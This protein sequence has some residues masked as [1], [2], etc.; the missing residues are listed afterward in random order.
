MTGNST[1][2]LVSTLSNV[3]VRF[4]VTR[5]SSQ[6]Q[7]QPDLTKT[8]DT[9]SVQNYVLCPDYKLSASILAHKA[10]VRAVLHPSENLIFSASR[11]NTVRAWKRTL[12]KGS[13]SNPA[14]GW[15]LHR[16]YAGHTHFVNALA[17]LSPSQEFPRGLLFSSGSDK[18]IHAYDPD[19]PSAQRE[20]QSETPGGP[21]PVVQP[22]YTL[23]GHGDN[24]CAL[25]VSKG[26][27]V[28]S[29]SWDKTAKLWHSFQ[30]KTT[31]TGHTQAVWSVLILQA[32]TSPQAIPQPADPANPQLAQS[33]QVLTASADKTIKRWNV[34]GKCLNT[35]E[36][37]TDAVRALAEVPGV[38]FASAG[39]DMTV[40]I[41]T[42]DGDSLRVLE[43]HSS[44]VYSLVVSSHSGE[45]VSSGE[46]RAVKVWKDSSSLQTLTHSCTSVWSVALSP[47]AD[48][49]TGGSDGFV[50]VFTRQI[51]RVA[52]ADVL[53]SWSEEVAATTIPTSQVGSVD[54]SK[55]DPVESLDKRKGKKEGEVVMVRGKNGTPEAYEWS[56]SSGGWSKIGD[57]VDAK[58]ETKKVYQGKEYDFVFDVELGPGVPPM[59][60][61]YNLSDNPWNAA[62]DF[63][64]KNDLSQEF[65]DQIA[66]F[67]VQQT[68]G[69]AGSALPA[70]GGGVDPFTG[71]GR[72]VPGGQSG[73]AG[74]M[75]SAPRPSP[76][77]VSAP[78]QNAP[79]PF[80]TGAYMSSGGDSARATASATEPLIPKQGYT[81]FKSANV[82]AIVAKIVKDNSDLQK[83]FDTTTA[84]LSAGE[85]SR[86]EAIGHLLEK[87]PSPKSFGPAFTDTDLGIIKRIA[88][89]WPIAKRLPGLDLLRLVVLYS[90][91]PLRN[92]A[93]CG[94]LEELLVAAEFP[95]SNNASSSTKEAENNQMLVL[96][97]I[98][99]VMGAG[100]G[101]EG[102]WT[103]RSKYSMNKNLRLALVTVVLN[104]SVLLTIK[105]DESFAM[106][107]L[108]L[109]TDFLKGES[110][111]DNEFRAYV[112]IGTLLH[113]YPSLKDAS[114]VAELKGMLGRSVGKDEVR[115]IQVT[116]ELKKV[117]G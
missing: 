17:Y 47:S 110:D 12:G 68:G 79:S 15:G 60:L 59:K 32:K 18:L 102:V 85:I 81:M 4:G 6:P 1:A 22:E 64:W 44:F 112:A 14:N 27:W 7:P 30:L 16:T 74:T 5:F 115:L 117:I 13:A 108:S 20:A 82:G 89:Q 106:D 9:G 70:G 28:A 55:L 88:T 21:V 72:Y 19:P 91:V 40:R 116:E 100:E 84:S 24:V 46:D 66:N 90:P 23:V 94:I 8:N 43:G 78:R 75:G 77:A 86:V 31:L 48:V 39:N 57:I 63:I 83:A 36:G 103:R 107:L 67:I 41:W 37:H 109:L 10:D 38:G 87:D 80:L 101:R 65:L 42:L 71:G 97:F 51:E 35:Y 111:R 62:Q 104:L 11:D 33:P 98:G 105:R 49:V 2:E 93:S 53:K 113:N 34:T 95:E 61:P 52:A 45:L 50:R 73:V 3:T 58:G 69:Q 25:A 29:G 114:T 56:A 99:N 92:P 76:G 26:A 54:V 96:R